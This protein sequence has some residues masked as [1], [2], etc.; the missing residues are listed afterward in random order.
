MIELLLAAEGL[1]SAGKLDQAERLFEQVAEAD[2]RNA[3]AVVGL[4][5]VAL[6]RGDAGAALATARRALDIDPQEAA[7]RRLVIRLEGAAVPPAAVTVATA[8]TVAAP[9]TVAVPAPARRS[10]L[11]RLR[12]FLLGR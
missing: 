3:I 1:L 9:A 4:A 10:W 11:E 6:E 5:R 2:P 8:V 12:R 7:A